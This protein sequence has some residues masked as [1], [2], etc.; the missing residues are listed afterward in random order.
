MEYTVSSPGWLIGQ[1]GEEKPRMKESS[2]Q[3]EEG[4]DW[5]NQEVKSEERRGENLKVQSFQLRTEIGHEEE[6]E[7]VRP[8]KMSLLPA[9]KKEWRHSTAVS[10]WGKKEKESETEEV[11]VE[12]IDGLKEFAS[13]GNIMSDQSRPQKN[14]KNQ[15]RE[16]VSSTK[17]YSVSGLSSNN[18]SSN[19]SGV[20]SATTTVTRNSSFSI[21]HDNTSNHGLDENVSSA[22][23]P[24]I[25]LCPDG[26]KRSCSAT[27]GAIKPKR[28]S[29]RA[30]HSDINDI[31]AKRFASY[32]FSI[33]S[34]TSASGSARDS[35]VHERQFDGG[36]ETLTL[37]SPATSNLEFDL[38]GFD[39]VRK[40]GTNK[41]K[42]DKLNT[43]L[44]LEQLKPTNKSVNTKSDRIPQRAGDSVSSKGADGDGD[45]LHGLQIKGLE[46]DQSAH[47]TGLR[48]PSCV[49][50]LLCESDFDSG[51]EEG[52]ALHLSQFTGAVKT[53]RE[54]QEFSGTIPRR[55]GVSS[56]SASPEKMHQDSASHSAV[57]AVSTLQGSGSHQMTDKEWGEAVPHWGL[58]NVRFVVEQPTESFDRR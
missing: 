16:E 46:S 55:H 27:N 58:Q 26:D 54:V 7:E 6:T 23:I 38:P 36:L 45:M 39:N 4:R 20:G 22:V 11:F 48:G 10:Q 40:L 9:K 17:H 43:L 47:P 44:R 13:D 30:A 33:T 57:V 42:S 51:I 31:G 28:G 35:S 5:L 50:G 21:D 52:E 1:K 24:V 18:S 56:G 37:T 12:K 32:N 25:K 29:N 41:L 49:D 34:G 3:A 8:E 2:F 15:A 14:E 19:P 53:E